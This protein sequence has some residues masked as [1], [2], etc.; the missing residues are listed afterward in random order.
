MGN[1]REGRC[2][3]ARQNR[4]AGKGVGAT[5]ECMSERQSLFNL[6]SKTAFTRVRVLRIALLALINYLSV[7]KVPAES[8]AICL[9]IFIYVGKH[10]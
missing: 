10:S 4:L 5:A 9:V 6:W 7:N 2:A 1:A 3:C 8:S